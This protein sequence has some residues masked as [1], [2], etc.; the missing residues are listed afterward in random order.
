MKKHTRGVDIDGAFSSHL[1]KAL[2]PKGNSRSR[3]SAAAPMML[4][5]LKIVKRGHEH[6]PGYII[7]VVGQAIAKAEGK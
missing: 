7:S 2:K 6:Y 1:M 4:M 3:L 5:A